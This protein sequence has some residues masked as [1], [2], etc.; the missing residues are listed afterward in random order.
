MKSCTQYPIVIIDDFLNDPDYV[1]DLA[2]SVEYGIDDG[3]VYPGQRSDFVS[4]IDP[5]LFGHIGNKL[6][7][8]FGQPPPKWI[9]EM[10][11]QKIPPQFP[12]DKFDVRNRGWA[13]L[14]GPDAY[15]GGV[16]FLNKNPDPNTGTNIYKYKNGFLQYLPIEREY[17]F[18][19]YNTDSSIDYNEYKKVYNKFHEQVTVSLKVDNYYNRLVLFGGD[20]PHG[21]DT[22][23]KEDRYT[24]VFFA[25]DIGSGKSYDNHSPLLR[26]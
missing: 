2:L 20:T 13:H 21:A 26:F 4:N 16:I 14:D 7:S 24:L 6:F 15:F 3:G 1:R 18:M 17:K 22:F 8:I 11:F 25:T 12:E 19:H 5:R 10:Y 9:I 23:G